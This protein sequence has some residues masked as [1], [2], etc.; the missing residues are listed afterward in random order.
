MPKPMRPQ[1]R[2]LDTQAPQRR[3]EHEVVERNQHHHER[4][5]QRLH[6]RGLKPLGLRH[7]VRL[8][9]PGR[10]LLIEQ[11][12]ERRD[13]REHD[14]DA[15]HRAHAV[16]GLVR[17]TRARAIELQ[18]R[19]T[20]PKPSTK[21]ERETRGGDEAERSRIIANATDREHRADAGDDRARAPLSFAARARA[22]CARH[23]G[24]NADRRRGRHA[25][26]LLAAQPEARPSR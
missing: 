16:D 5:I 15:Q 12:P 25:H 11:R 4:R 22:P 10:R 13:E 6:L 19:P 21:H 7:L 9:H 2:R 23:A 17:M 8:Q 3:I 20:P 18:S 1:R 26:V 24:T 14:Q